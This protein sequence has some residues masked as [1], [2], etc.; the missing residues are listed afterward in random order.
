MPVS[1]AEIRWTGLDGP[2]NGPGIPSEIELSESF[3]SIASF[4]SSDGTAVS[5]R[6]IG[7]S[8]RGH[9]SS[10]S[11]APAEDCTR[12]SWWPNTSPTS[13]SSGHLP[14]AGTPRAGRAGPVAEALSRLGGRSQG[15]D[16]QDRPPGTPGRHVVRRHRRP[17]R[18][19]AGPP[20]RS[21][22]LWEPPLYAAGEELAPVLGEFEELTAN[23]DGG[24]PIVCW[25]RRWPASRLRCWTSWMRAS[26]PT[27]S[28]GTHSGT[29]LGTHP[30]KRWLVP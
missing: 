7:A 28:P 4:E 25:R 22:V 8:A 14:A 15:T 13:A 30:R 6:R 27:T 18:R 2:R 19:T 21:L 26:P 10:W 24:E 16:R 12:G 11:M 9:R 5:Y 1:A 3:A 29:H 23:D 20:V 17:A